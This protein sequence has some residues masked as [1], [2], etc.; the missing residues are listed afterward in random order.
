MK[1]ITIIASLFIILSCASV[2]AKSSP[3]DI[4]GTWEGEMKSGMGGPPMH[5]TFNFKREG[6]TVKGTVNGAPG[7]WIPLEDLKIKGKKIS[8]TVT[9]KMGQTEMKIKY[10]GKIKGEKI[11][12]S[13]KNE[14]PGGFGGKRKPV[15]IGISSGV[16]GGM[17]GGMGPQAS[18]NEFT[19]KRVSNEPVNP[20]N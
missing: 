8:F 6:D 12:L 9:S 19:L 7:Q 2:S 3:V 4:D 16:G 14:S 10:K 17:G 11:K 18:L 15:G 20:V 1:I 5:V 13:Y